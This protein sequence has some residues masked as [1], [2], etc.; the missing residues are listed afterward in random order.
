MKKWSMSNDEMKA[1]NVIK[2]NLRKGY[3]SISNVRDN[4]I[5]GKIKHFLGIKK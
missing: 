4:S 2:T 1:L 3:L 5:K